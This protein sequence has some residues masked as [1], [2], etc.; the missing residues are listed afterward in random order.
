MLLCPLLA[1]KLGQ[2]TPIG[3]AVFWGSGLLAAIIL[4]GIVS[5]QKSAL[6]AVLEF[7]PVRY[8]GV[9]SYG[10]YIYHSIVHM[11][12]ALEIPSRV[13]AVTEVL[14]GIGVASLSWHLI[15]RPLLDLR[16]RVRARKSTEA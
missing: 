8:I 12:E 14:L 7:R 3:E 1:S 4:T 13:R 2:T 6:V 11:P 10:I 9:I 16:D 5:D 15:E